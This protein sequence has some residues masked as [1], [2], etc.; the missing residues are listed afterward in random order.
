[1]IPISWTNMR[2]YHVARHME[3]DHILSLSRLTQFPDDCRLDIKIATSC[4]RDWNRAPFTVATQRL[5]HNLRSVLAKVGIILPEPVQIVGGSPNIKAVTLRSA[6][7]AVVFAATDRLRAKFKSIA[8]GPTPGNERE[9]ESENKQVCQA[10]AN[11]LLF[12]IVL[13]ALDLPVRNA[14]RKQPICSSVQADTYYQQFRFPICW[15]K[16]ALRNGLEI[17]QEFKLC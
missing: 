12:T 11:S 7:L 1:M 3:K 9:R 6:Q 10:D 8:T 13:P 17:F 5:R 4:R 15:L 16:A 14:V 2:M